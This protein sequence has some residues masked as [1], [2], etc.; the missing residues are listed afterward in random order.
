M[1][2]DVEVRKAKRLMELR[3]HHDGFKSADFYYSVRML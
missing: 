2:I 1:K 3:I